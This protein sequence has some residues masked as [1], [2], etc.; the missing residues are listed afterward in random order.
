LSSVANKN[1]R[2]SR[3]LQSKKSAYQPLA[4][5]WTGTDAALLERMLAF[6]PK[7]PPQKILDATVNAGRF[8]NGTKRSVLGIDIDIRHRPTVVADNSRMPFK[9]HYFD[10]VVYDPPHI[11][12]QGKDRSKDFNRRFGL[13]IKSSS[14]LG[15][16]F[17]HTFPPFVREAYRVLR[18]DGVLLCKIADYVHGHRF[19]WAH[20]ELINAA[21]AVGFTACDCIVKIRR[22]PITDPRWKKAHHARRHHCYWLVFRRSRKCE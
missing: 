15:Y 3:I 12:N 1:L 5:V 18:A 7:S 14:E 2:R 17:S 22:A 8:W 19:Q 13:I 4:S 21:I 16:N 11:P 20:V 6:Y 9:E 10:V